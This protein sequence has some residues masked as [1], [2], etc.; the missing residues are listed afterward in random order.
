[1]LAWLLH[2]A[3]GIGM[4]VYLV[5]HVFGLRALYNPVH[6][7]ELMS[8][9]RSPLFKVGELLLLIGVSYHSVNGFRIVMIDFLGWSPQQKKMFYT[10]LGLSIV[11]VVLGGYP[12]VAFL[13]AK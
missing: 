12:I 8:E 5:L 11:L 4:M 6:F 10:T 3:T 13:L 9:Y 2:R 7:D 1:M